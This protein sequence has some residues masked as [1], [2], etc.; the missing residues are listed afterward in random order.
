MD[1]E[2]NHIFIRIVSILT[3]LYVVRLIYTHNLRIGSSWFLLA[4]GTSFFV[5]SIWPNAIE[6]LSI[7][8]GTNSWVSN[9]LFFFII[10]LF[11][12][13]IHCTI[14][15]SGLINRVKELGQELTLLTSDINEEKIKNEAGA[16]HT[17]ERATVHPLIAE[18]LKNMPLVPS[19][20]KD[21]ETNSQS[22]IKAN[23]LLDKKVKESDRFVND[24]SF[25]PDGN[26]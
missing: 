7:F 6:I 24:I 22:E 10:F 12:I 13:V 8:T 17:I 14:M 3:L 19:G 16:A 25:E 4:L 9:I 20:A 26:G 23:I 1:L 11:I 18:D 21:R 2:V 15:I 5:L